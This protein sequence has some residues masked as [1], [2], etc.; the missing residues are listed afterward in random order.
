MDCGLDL[1]QTELPTR[2][3]LGVDLDPRGIFLG[4]VELH[5]GDTANRR[6]FLR[7][8]GLGVVIDLGELERGRFEIEIEDRL[9]GGV[10][11]AISRGDWVS[12]WESVPMMP[13]SR[14]RHP[15]PRRRSSD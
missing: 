2:Q 1:L 7:D 3:L 9:V 14:L 4:A 8:V 10:D 15:A 5:L 11:F 12:R 6:K 13:K